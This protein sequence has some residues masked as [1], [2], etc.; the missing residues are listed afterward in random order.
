GVS[1]T[2]TTRSTT[3]NTCISSVTNISVNA[4][5]SAAFC[6]PLAD[7]DNDST[8]EDTPVV[9]NVLVGD[10]FGGYGPSS[11]SIIVATQPSN[12]VASVNNNGTPNDPTDDT[13]LYSPNANYFGPDSFTYTITDLNGITSTA[14]VTIAV[15]SD[16]SDLPTAVNDL[17]SATEDT[18]VSINVLVNDSFGGDG[19]SA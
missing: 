9:I 19:P 14:T 8:N 7:D 13:I 4:A 6:S 1:H 5:L 12:G 16:T 11:G 3:D 15:V 10:T 18:P 2:F 17:A